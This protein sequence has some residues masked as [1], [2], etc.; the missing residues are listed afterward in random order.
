[1]AIYLSKAQ[2]T[3]AISKLN[4]HWQYQKPSLHWHYLSEAQGYQYMAKYYIIIISPRSPIMTNA[5]D[6]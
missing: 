6:S 3:L 2:F 5:L 1:M 4:S